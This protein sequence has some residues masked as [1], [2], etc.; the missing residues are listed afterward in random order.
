MAERLRLRA[1][2]LFTHDAQCRIESTNEWDGGVAPRFYLERS[3]EGT[4]CRFRADLP[5]TLVAQLKE[6][7]ARESGA[8]TLSKLPLFYHEYIQLL[9]AHK[10]IEQI[11]SG[12]AYQFNE[13]T[14]L[15]P[16]IEPIPI[17]EA[18]LSLLEG[19][20]EGWIP[21][22]PHRQPFMAIIEDGKAISLCTSVRITEAIHEAGIET[23]PAYRQKGYAVN[24]A[25]GWAKAVREIDALPFY[26][27]SWE[28][29]A[30]QRV[31]ARLG[32]SL[33]GIDFH[34]T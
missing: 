29:V 14:K 4:L 5:D 26:S 21:D 8:E 20:F 31:A 32:L 10:P 30:S 2:A 15:A 9:A 22:V 18:N 12:P 33:F 13:A 28:N 34:I 16:S 24:V 19:G 1:E 17:T 7:C 6:I 23:L 25:A 27:T 3:P 11:W